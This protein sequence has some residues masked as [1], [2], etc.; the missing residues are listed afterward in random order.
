MAFEV[1]RSAACSRDLGLILEHLVEAYSA[2]GEPLPDAFDRAARR[3]RA[4]EADMMSL[5]EAPFQGTVRPALAPGLRQVTKN[6]AIFYFDID[7]MR[8]EVRVLA[9][10]FGGQDHQRHMLSRLGADVRPR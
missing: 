4:I 7:E 5:G 8:G 10:F 1:V 2:F 6:K 3:I 9:V